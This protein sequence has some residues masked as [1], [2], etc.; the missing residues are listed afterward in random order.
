M[1]QVGWVELRDADAEQCELFFGV[2]GRLPNSITPAAPFGAPELLKGFDPSSTSAQ[3]ELLAACTLLLG[4]ESPLH[5]A[6]PRTGAG[7]PRCFMRELH[8]WR[9]GKG[10]AFPISPP[11]A[12]DG[13]VLDLLLP[14]YDEN[15]GRDCHYLTFG[16]EGE[17]GAKLVVAPQPDDL[18]IRNAPYL[19]PPP[20]SL[21]S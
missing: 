2:E 8:D 10:A 4:A 6:A 1:R 9:K 21:E 7:A 14:P 12:F 20:P 15:E 5:R 13:A 11:S 17:E 3:L 18:V 19:G 16:R